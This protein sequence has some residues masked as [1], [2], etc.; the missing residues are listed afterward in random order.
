[1]AKVCYFE[2][3]ARA[4]PI[5]LLLKHAEVP[6]TDEHPDKNG[7]KLWSELK[8][9]FPERGQLPWYT[10]ENGKVFNQSNAILRTLAKQ[11]GYKSDDPWVQYECDW[12]FEVFVDCKE[13][14]KF[15][16]PFYKGDEATD[17]ERTACLGLL[18]KC[19]D[20]LEN[21]FKDNRK[22]CAGDQ[23]TAADF[24]LLGMDVAFFNN[25][26]LKTPAFG[27]TLN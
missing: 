14:S 18:T 23:I 7:V 6:F 2:V 22:Y 4:C 25:P 20:T 15:I 21:K 19:L 12:L 13:N 16:I 5:R 10:D 8:A 3:N 24:T 17:E 9:E 26:N 27:Q 1:M 11:H